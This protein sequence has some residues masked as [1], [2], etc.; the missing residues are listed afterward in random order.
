MVVARFAAHWLPCML[1]LAPQRPEV[2]SAEDARVGPR[3]PACAHRGHALPQ[4]VH[5][6]DKGGHVAAWEEPELFA[7]E[8]RAGF[9]PLRT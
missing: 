1:T 7:D 6:V 9:R 8:V 3:G 2:K 5:E 4:F